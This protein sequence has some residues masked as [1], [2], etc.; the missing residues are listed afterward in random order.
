M[1][2]QGQLAAQTT[3]KRAERTKRKDM[4]STS[5]IP[6]GWIEL[7][8]IMSVARAYDNLEARVYWRLESRG[9]RLEVRHSTPSI[10]CGGGMPYYSFLF[11]PPGA[12]TFSGTG[13]F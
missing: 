9:Q 2:V 7:D 3:A 6:P 5:S 12:K 10:P 11:S 4:F 13:C 1:Q 8:S